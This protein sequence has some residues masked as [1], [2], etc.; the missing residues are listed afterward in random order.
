MLSPIIKKETKYN[1]KV[2]HVRNF[3]AKSKSLATAVTRF[4]TEE[5]AARS[6]L[7]YVNQ[8]VQEQIDAPKR[9]KKSKQVTVID[10]IY[11]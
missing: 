2:V 1:L 11:I 4:C 7:I 10:F 6:L 3:Y 8:A 5:S 9:K